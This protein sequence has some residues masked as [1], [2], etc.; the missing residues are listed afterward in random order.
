MTVFQG[1]LY[2][3]TSNPVTGM[4]AWMTT[5]GTVWNND[6]TG[7]FGNHF[8]KNT[9]WSSALT[10]FNNQLFVGTSNYDPATHLSENGGEVWAWTP[11]NL[12]ITLFLPNVQ[13]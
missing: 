5:D 8:N 10:T 11:A 13:H 1:V 7:G 4:E 6:M 12:T 2:A 3:F 9:L